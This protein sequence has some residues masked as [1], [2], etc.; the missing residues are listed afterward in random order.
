LVYPALVR[1]FRVVAPDLLGFGGTKP[2]TGIDY[3]RRAWTD[4]VLAFVD[5][6]RID[7]CSLVGNSLGG[8]IAFS[9]AVARPEMVER[10]VA[11]GSV[12]VEM[13]V[14]P[15][16]EKVWGYE[17]STA[18]MRE[19]VELFPYDKSIATDDLVQ[20]RYRQSIEPGIHE[21]YSAMFPAPRQRWLDDLALTDDELASI[22]RPVL[23]IHGRDD[24]VIPYNSSLQ[25]LEKLP[26]ARLLLIG[27]C[28]H[29][30]MIEHTDE[31]R[32]VVTSFILS[33]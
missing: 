28:G 1:H 16:L 2:P 19:L 6:L 18:N 27:R 29:W 23:L 26:D 8:A 20:L 30:V 32:S 22:D 9:A 31:F 11:M 12:G 21:A 10:V 24:E 3:G 4:H 15:G 7:S 14:S 25:L 5:A 17:P 13:T 33:R